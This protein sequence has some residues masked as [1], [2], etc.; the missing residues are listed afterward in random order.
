ML[1]LGRYLSPV[2][3]REQEFEQKF[4]GYDTE[5]VDDFFYQLSAD[6][7]ALYR[8]NQEQIE[9]IQKLEEEL[10][11]YQKLE[12]HL[13]SALITA[14]ETAEKVLAHADEEKALIRQKAELEA[15]E[16]KKRAVAEV[17]KA[18]E[19]LATL[20]NEAITFRSQMRA[21]LISFNELLELNLLPAAGSYLEAA[22]AKEETD[23]SCSG[24]CDQQEEGSGESKPDSQPARPN[25]FRADGDPQ[26]TAKF[27][28]DGLDHSR[29]E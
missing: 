13:Q 19:Q 27:S 21:L 17:A 10:S 23:A 15:E 24:D 16:I 5:A 29:R 4:R 8:E 20:K 11:R 14:Q 22:A 18:Q 25:D 7:E 6:Y 9:K 12:N 26:S 28:F 2:E 3:V 1:K